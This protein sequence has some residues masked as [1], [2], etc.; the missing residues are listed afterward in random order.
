MP[1]HKPG[2]VKVSVYVGA[3]TPIGTTTFLYTDPNKELLKQ[4]ALF[5][6][7]LHQQ[8][9]SSD[10]ETRGGSQSNSSSTQSAGQ[11]LHITSLCDVATVMG[12]Q[13]V[14]NDVAFLGLRYHLFLKQ[15]RTWR[16]HCE[17]GSLG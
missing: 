12:L 14:P 2:R 16:R 11:P 13:I 7:W 3:G 10:H 8:Q 1:N 15:R 9:M 4:M 6:N 17:G 5:M